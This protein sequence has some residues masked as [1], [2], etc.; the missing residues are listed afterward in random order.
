MPML[1]AIKSSRIWK[2]EAGPKLMRHKNKFEDK[3]PRVTR[4]QLGPRNPKFG[5]WFSFFRPP[6]P[7]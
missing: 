5:P 1:G 4:S 7:V 3:F 2:T 6:F